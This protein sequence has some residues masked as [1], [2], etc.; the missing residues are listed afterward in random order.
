MWKFLTLF[1]VF[2]QLAC[3]SDHEF[4]HE[5]WFKGEKCTIDS[6]S[7]QRKKKHF[8]KLSHSSKERNCSWAAVCVVSLKFYNLIYFTVPKGF[9]AIYLSTLVVN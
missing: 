3:Q 4:S 1:N 6:T 9:N 7:Q 8:E 2:Q 5:Y